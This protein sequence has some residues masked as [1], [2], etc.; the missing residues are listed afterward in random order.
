M[1]ITRLEHLHHILD[2][3]TNRSVTIRVVLVLNDS[4][5]APSVIHSTVLFFSGSAKRVRVRTDTIAIRSD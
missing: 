1:T 5:N 2:S 3:D 4:G